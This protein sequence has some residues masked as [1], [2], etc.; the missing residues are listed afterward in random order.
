MNHIK[1]NCVDLFQEVVSSLTDITAVL[2]LDLLV[3][4][5]LILSSTV[6]CSTAGK[7]NC[8][9]ILVKLSWSNILIY[10][11]NGIW[12]Y[13]FQPHFSLSQTRCTIRI[14][15][16]INL[17]TKHPAVSLS[18]AITAKKEGWDFGALTICQVP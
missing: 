7:R 8:Y 6:S 9:C 15:F 13:Y 1:S 18:P 10:K 12:I 14:Q 16:C 3:K 5:T 11:Y 17:S 4:S 2:I